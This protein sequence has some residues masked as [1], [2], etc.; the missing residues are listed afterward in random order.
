MALIAALY[1][2]I[3]A[4]REGN[5]KKEKE[6]T[7]RFSSRLMLELLYRMLFFSNILE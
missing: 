2:G 3:R 4:E 5:K 6:G 7:E 1:G